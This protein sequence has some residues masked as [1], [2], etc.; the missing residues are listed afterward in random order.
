MKIL[1]Y[2][3]GLNR[4]GVEIIV[5]Q[6][7]NYFNNKSAEI[8]VMYLYQDMADMKPAFPSNVILHPLPFNFN[9]KPYFQYFLYFKKLITLLKKIQPDIIHA[10]NSS[11]SYFFLASAIQWAKIQPIN[12]RTLHSMGFFLERKTLIDKLRFF[13]DKKASEFLKTVIVSV[14]PKV[15]DYVDD[16]YPLNRSVLITNGIDAKK[17]INTKPP[18]ALLGIK[19]D[20]IVGI[21]IARICKGKN[22]KLLL[23]SWV[24]VVE[25]YP[26]ALL[27]L[28]GDGPLKFE[29]EELCK[30]MGIK[31]NVFFTGS[32]P[33]AAD[34][35]S[36]ADIG[37]FPS[38]SEGFGLGLCEMMAAGLPVIVSNIPA[39]QSI[40]RNGNNGLF[41]ETYDSKD[42][43]NKIINIIANK[44]MA[45]ELGKKAQEDV[46][47]NFTI[48]IMLDKYKELYKKE[49]DIR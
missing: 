43:S 20:R 1:Y 6:L 44:K 9:K 25:C 4:G 31:D 37:I 24:R 21:Y 26:T 48:D 18:K 14:G 23:Q 17:I 19:A 7:A 16:N 30:H 15:K 8:H 11:F 22:H 27:I 38:E 42:L 32:V 13:F 39:F 12:I 45:V 46:F 10:H 33:N 40:I 3:D 28:I 36:I 35:L 29:Y 34:Y 2:L 5:T 41:F 49:L 47:N